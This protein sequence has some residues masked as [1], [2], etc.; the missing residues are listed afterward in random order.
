MAR[1]YVAEERVT[2]AVTSRNNTGCKRR[3]LWVRAALLATQLCGKHISA[4]VNQHATIEEAVFPVG[5]APRLCDEDLTQL[6]REL[7]SGV[8]RCYIELRESTVKG[9]WKEM[10]WKELGRAKKASSVIWSYS[11]TIMN[12]LRVND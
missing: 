7:S 4:A 6:E 10:G 11:E 12:P 1:T 3:S 8:G 2:Y 9:I 5:V